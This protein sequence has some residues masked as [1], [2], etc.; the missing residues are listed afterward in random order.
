MKFLEDYLNRSLLKVTR[1]I[2]ALCLVLVVLS[3]GA[4][5]WLTGVHIPDHVSVE[6]GSSDVSSVTVIQAL[7]FLMI[8]NPECPDDPS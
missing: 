4:C 1:A 3:V 2:H 6:I 5:E 8:P 7:H